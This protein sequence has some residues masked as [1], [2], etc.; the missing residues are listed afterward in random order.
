MRKTVISYFLLFTFL[1]SLIP[2]GLVYADNER[3]QLNQLHNEITGTQRELEQGQRNERNLINQIQALEGQV[4]AVQAEIDA[5]RGNIELTRG[6]I[7]EA[8]AD[9]DALEADL[10]EQ[11]ENLNAR[12][13]AMYING[14][15]GVLDVLLG[16]N[17]INDFMLNISR[18]QLIFESDMEV[19]EALEEQYRILETHRQYLNDLEAELVAERE[20]EASKQAALRQNQDQ[21]AAART[22]VAQNNRY[23]A[24]VLDAKNA[25]AERLIA[26]ILSQQ[27]DEEYIGGQMRWPVPGRTR[28]SSEFGYRMHPILRTNRMHTGIDIPAPTGTPI[29]AAN[30]GRVITSGWNN[31]FGNMVVIDH[32]GGITTLYA[33]NSENL[34]RVGDIVAP[35]Q[36][37]ARVGSTGMSTGPHLHFEVRVNGAPRNPRSYL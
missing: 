2:L 1:I 34:V 22:E 3:D 37:I 4:R 10:A 28:V 11:Q 32:G 31:S 19:M 25:E 14:N 13:R 7:R 20:R 17:S 35:G 9:L 18:A 21:V 24:Q 26:I 6:R 30:G 33:H 27:G 5:L 12:L 36:Q 15:I 23:L 16:S 29:V 8:Q